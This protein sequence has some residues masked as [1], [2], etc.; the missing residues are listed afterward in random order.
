MLGRDD[1]SRSVSLREHWRLT[2][3]AW[4][5]ADRLHRAISVDSF[6]AHAFLNARNVGG[7]NEECDVGLTSVQ[8]LIERVSLVRTRFPL[9]DL[10]PH[11]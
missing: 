8:T 7:R 3:T 2:F 10:H 5:P 9:G 11:G 4:H 1:S 6:G